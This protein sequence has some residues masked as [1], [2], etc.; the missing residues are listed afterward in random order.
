MLGV[1]KIGGA[2]FSEP[3]REKVESVRKFVRNFKGELAFVAGGGELTKRYLSLLRPLGFSEGFLDYVGIEMTHVNAR[4]LARVVDGVYCRTFEQVSANIK[5]RPVTGGQVP[6]QSTDAVAAELADFLGADVLIL[7]KDVGG[8]Y[9]A[10]PK[11]DRGARII[12]SM[13]FDDL[14]RFITEKSRAGYYGVI[15]PQAIMIITRIRI[16]T[17]VVGLDFDFKEGTA[18]EERI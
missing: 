15:D 5:R 12:H 14:K 11:E 9:T 18:I 2:F 4:V 6:G 17:Y 10:N 13:T 1:V 8:I 16:P 3:D 7:V